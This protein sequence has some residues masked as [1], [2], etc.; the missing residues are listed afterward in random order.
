MF[1]LFL[2]PQRPPPSPKQRSCNSLLFISGEGGSV[3]H[4]AHPRSTSS[5]APA[6]SSPLYLKAPL[7][8]RSPCFP[9]WT[10]TQFLP[11]RQRGLVDTARGIKFRL[12]QT[13]AGAEP[14]LAERLFLPRC[15]SS[16]LASGCLLPTIGLFSLI[17]PDF[18]RTFVG[19]IKYPIPPCF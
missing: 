1:F 4:P 6:P 19:Q 14:R 13:A 10:R 3:V 8:E 18:T 11:S 9:G 17:H 5:Q 15:G 16:A 12:C 7:G 2:F